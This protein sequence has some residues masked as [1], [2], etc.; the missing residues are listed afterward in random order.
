M[1]TDTTMQPMTKAR[2][3][4][5]VMW[6]N[7]ALTAACN[8]AQAQSV[9]PPDAAE[10]AMEE[11]M[12][13]GTSSRI[14]DDLSSVPGT[15][16]VISNAD[17]AEQALF[18]TDLGEILA[19][20][21]P[22]YGV[23]SSGNFS[24]ANQTMRG[25]RPAVFIDGIPTT[26]PLRDGGRDLRLISP[27]AIGQVEVISGST[28][29]YGLGG[30]GGLINFATRLPGE[31]DWEFQTDMSVGAAPSDI[32]DSLTYSL[33]QAAMGKEGP[34][35]FVFT[36]FYESFDSFFD[37]EGDRIPPD[38]QGQGGIAESEAYNLFAKVSYDLS[39]E[40]RLLFSGNT[41]NITADHSYVNGF[42][43]F[44]SE[45]SPA[46][47]ETP[48]G[49]DQS[50]ENSLVY[51]TYQNDDL[52]SSAVTAQLF[53]S[54]YEA[55]FPFID[56]AMLGDFELPIFPPDGGQS[57][58][59]AERYGIRFDVN[60]PVAWGGREGNILWGIDYLID[61]TSQPLTDGR[62]LVPVLEQTSIA[63]F[64]Q[65]Q[66]AMADWLDLVGGFRYEDAEI[67]ADTF[68]TIP[69]SIAQPG[70]TT[71]QGGSLK[72]EEPLFN[73]GVVF[74]P[75]DSG[76]LSSLDLYAGF[77]QGF[78][79]NDFGRALRA[80]TETSIEAFDFE[81]QTTDSY[82]VGVRYQN[83]VLDVALAAYFSESNLGSSFNLQTLEL[84][85]APEEVWGL[86]ATLDFAATDNLN[87]G[88][89]FAWVDGEKELED[90][91]VEDLDTTRIA[92]AKFVA[93][94]DQ[95]FAQHW[96]VRGQI[97]HSARQQRFDNEP[98]FGRADIE[99]FTLVDVFVSADLGPGR[100]TLAFNNLLDEY[101][102]TPD[103]YR[104]ASDENFTTGQ[105]MTV[106][107]TY[108]VAY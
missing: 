54:D 101:Y 102:F 3:Y 76:S 68:T 31:G 40:S 82:E 30:A 37:A 42:G 90:G 67:K 28:A 75:F 11:V 12:V 107:L 1:S 77:S 6:A 13:Y 4:R 73:L 14:S 94:F 80:T 2:I 100:A 15:V 88:A 49:E 20:E 103:A 93:Y 7:L 35:G 92:P 9:A 58:I 41:Y 17:L 62:D 47:K 72:Y 26:V 33:S 83:D 97:T 78:A 25:R 27:L 104:S 64:V 38:P 32:S 87:L 52:A 34:W 105:G 91:T 29:I 66:I 61:E 18:S 86:E 69:I 96:Q 108:S 43:E 36:G 46:I 21:V 44:P 63:P 79:V 95:K 16:Q 24:N 85:R 84:D 106:K 48:P 50:T 59:E 53:Y 81:A 55:V 56:S 57:T 45:P 10:P 5:S 70:G 8:A 98:V 23:S 74:H 19:R 60:T 22:G 89:S 99:S 65:V 51:V 71:V 39:D